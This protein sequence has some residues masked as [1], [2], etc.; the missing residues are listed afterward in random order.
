M[1]RGT[2]DAAYLALHGESLINLISRYFT[3]VLKGILLLPMF[4]ESQ[5]TRLRR[6]E[7]PKAI[8]SG[9]SMLN[10]SLLLFNPGWDVINTCLNACMHREKKSSGGAL[11]ERAH[12]CYMHK[13]S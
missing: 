4:A 3:E 6:D 5:S 12:Y 2:A 11:G 13:S 9:L 1:K 8:S 7:V 10:M